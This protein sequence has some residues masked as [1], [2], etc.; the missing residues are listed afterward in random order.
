MKKA[1]IFF[2]IS[3]ILLMMGSSFVVAQEVTM[4]ESNISSA[5]TGTGDI[6]GII[7]NSSGHPQENAHVVAFAFGIIGGPAIAVGSTASDGSYICTVPEGRY[8]VLAFKFGEGVAYAVPVAVEDG[9]TTELDL[10]LSG[11]LIPGAGP[12]STPVVEEEFNLESIA[13]T[14]HI[15]TKTAPTPPPLPTGTGDIQGIITNSS[16]HPQ[17]NAHVVAFAFGIIG[18]P[19]IAVGSTAS[20]GSYICTVP[21]GR[22]HVLAFKFGEGVAYA[23]PVAVED[24]QTTELDLSLSGGLIPGAGPVSQEVQTVPEGEVVATKQSSSTEESVGTGIIQG[25]ITNQHGTPIAFVR[26]IAVGNPNDPNT[27]LGFTVTHLLIGGKGW[28]NMRVPAGR[29]LFVR[30]A[31]LPFY[32]GAWAGPVQVGEGETTRLDLSITS[33]L[34]GS[35]QQTSMGTQQTMPLTR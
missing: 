30:A 32:L 8:H 7:T 10:S 18:G 21:E 24:G 31:K 34:P 1:R 17:E 22:Y 23:V 15:H 12:V 6:Q 13:S 33:L 29:Y 11:G 4:I 27:T 14:H 16:G 2:T 19:A 25:E 5:P 9:Q 3:L 20:D 26:V 35:T 28:Y